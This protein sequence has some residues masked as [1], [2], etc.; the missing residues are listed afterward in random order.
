MRHLGKDTE[1]E[2]IA[3][4]RDYKDYVDIEIERLRE[5]FEEKDVVIDVDQFMS[6][7]S[8]NAVGNSTVKAY[9]DE[10][11]N[12]LN[13]SLRDTDSLVENL[14]GRVEHLED[15]QITVDLG[16]S[17]T[18]TN[19]PQSR[20]VKSYADNYIAGKPKGFTNPSNRGVPIYDSA[21][22]QWLIQV[23]P[24]ASTGAANLTELADVMIDTPVDGQNLVWDAN[25][26]KFRNRTITGYDSVNKDV[27]FS[28]SG[29]LDSTN[30][31]INES[32]YVYSDYI[33]LSMLKGVKVTLYATGNVRYFSLFTFRKRSISYEIGNWSTYTINMDDYMDIDGA[34]YVRFSGRKIDAKVENLA[35]ASTFGIGD[36]YPE[37]IGN[38]FIQNPCYI[39][40]SGSFN[41]NASDAAGYIATKYIRVEA[42]VGAKYSAYVASSNALS[43]AFYDKYGNYISGLRR[44]TEDFYT[45]TSSDIP[46]GAYYAALCGMSSRYPIVTFAQSAIATVNKIEA[47]TPKIYRFSN[48]NG[49]AEEITDDITQIDVDGQPTSSIGAANNVTKIFL[50]KI[51]ASDKLYIRFRFKVND[52]INVDGSNLREIFTMVGGAT[53]KIGFLPTAFIQNTQSNLSYADLLGQAKIRN[54]FGTTNG[55]MFTLDGWANKR[56]CG[57]RSFGIRYIGSESSCI[58][59]NDGISLSTSVG[60]SWTLS[61]YET[62]YELYKAIEANGNYEVRPYEILERVPSELAKFDGIEMI[63]TRGGI[64]NNDWFYIPLAVNEEWHTFELMVDSGVYGSY[65]IV[66]IDGKGTYLPNS[67]NSTMFTAAGKNVTLYIGGSADGANL[68]ITYKDIEVRKYDTGDAEMVY[69]ATSGYTI[70]SDWSPR[71]LVY[72]MHDM[73]EAAAEDTTGQYVTAT[74][75]LYWFLD[76]ARSKGYQPVT[77]HQV[78]DH[79]ING[80]PVPRKSI[81]LVNDDIRLYVYLNRRL[82]SAFTANGWPIT[83]ALQ[84]NQDTYTYDGRTYD[85]KDIVQ[86]IRG[87][88]GNA[89][90]HYN[91]EN[92]PNT[93]SGWESWMTHFGLCEDKLIDTTIQIYVNGYT[94]PMVVNEMLSEGVKGAFTTTSGIVSRMSNP[95]RIPRLYIDNVDSV[96][97]IKNYVI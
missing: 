63:N 81:L 39:T 83:L 58:I 94:N 88:G 74:D 55:T 56:W 12:D 34:Y 48:S 21:S 67:Y 38:P 60:D 24:S 23:L 78:V 6:D 28:N 51:K 14:D 52:D 64:A 36:I 44:S 47:D 40:T 65:P 87:A 75:K 80:T 45:I 7:T 31:V 15:N 57:Q 13:T 91:G 46:E 71:I 2:D 42:L 26:K 22:G 97:K 82:R 25:T 33:P 85:V 43:L 76:L 3:T 72:T 30:G 17:D 77:A 10:C 53:N 8:T 90:S 9:V 18:S 1:Y 29:Y 16:L 54:L 70:L 37:I 27:I 86:M 49:C 61:Q 79:V 4:Q 89:H 41:T 32:T 96:G 73:S 62:V 35:P 5:E 19:P 66:S 50:G 93:V 95:L 68:D 20:V 92:V 59:Y 69:N 84:D 11:V